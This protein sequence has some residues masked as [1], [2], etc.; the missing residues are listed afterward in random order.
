MVERVNPEWLYHKAHMSSTD[1]QSSSEN[2]IETSSPTGNVRPSFVRPL[3]IAFVLVALPLVI[4]AVVICAIVPVVPWWVGLVLG[5]VVAAVVVANRFLRAHDVVV[6]RFRS[7][8]SQSAGVERA[9]NLLQ[10]LSLASGMSEPNLQVA[11][12]PSRNAAIVRKGDTATVIVTSGLLDSADVMQMEGLVAQVLARLKNGDAEWA[13]VSAAL[14]GLPILGT[15]LK[16]LLGPVARYAMDNG[17]SQDR[18]LQADREAVALTR[19]PPGLLK[20]LQLIEE[21]P[22]TTASAADGVEHLWIAAPDSEPTAISSDR[23]SLELR[24]DALAE[25]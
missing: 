23:A 1:A 16:G 24:I 22:G 20:A 4:L 13:T 12:D 21:S 19:Y 9:T 14:F 6:S 15:G 17:Q 2:H 25:L 18:D 8:T 3:S 11:A 5:L 10:S 7:G